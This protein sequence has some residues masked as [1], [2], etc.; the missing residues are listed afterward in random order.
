[1]ERVAYVDVVVEAASLW[2]VSALYADAIGSCVR[3]TGHGITAQGG[4]GLRIQLEFEHQKLPSQ[5][6]WE[7]G[8][9]LGLQ[10]EGAHVCRLWL[11]RRYTER[12][13]AP[14]CRRGRG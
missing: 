10:D 9:I 11:N 1:M 5:G 14:P 2:T 8:S 7:G 4:D 3:R 6:R 13:E 12:P